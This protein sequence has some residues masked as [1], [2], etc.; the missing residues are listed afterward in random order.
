MITRLLYVFIL[1]YY[2]KGF[3]PEMI[4]YKIAITANT[5]KMCSRLPVG[6]PETIPKNPRIQTTIQITAM[7]QIRLLIIFRFMVI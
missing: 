7:S 1:L 3:L 4:L 5:N 6:I 2:P